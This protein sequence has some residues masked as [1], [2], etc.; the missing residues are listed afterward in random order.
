MGVLARNVLKSMVG[1]KLI[2]S[3]QILLVRIIGGVSSTHIAETLRS[4]IVILVVI[5]ARMLFAQREK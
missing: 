3:L 5:I 2:E 4:R 1:K